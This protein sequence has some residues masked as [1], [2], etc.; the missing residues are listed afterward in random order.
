VR[1]LTS[2]SLRTKITASFILVV[3]AGT[4][5][6]VLVGSRIVTRA[7]L[8]QA[9]QRTAQ[10]LETAR[11]LCTLRQDAVHEAVRRAGVRWRTEGS[12]GESPELDLLA[13]HP[14]GAPAPGDVVARALRGEAS[15]GVELV[16]DRL[17]LGA[18]V[19]VLEKGAVVGAVHGAVHVGAGSPALREIEALVLGGDG[20]GAATG[21]VTITPM[22]RPAAPPREAITAAAPLAGP[23]GRPAGT[24]LVAIRER[25]YLAARTQMMLTFLVVAAAGVLLVLA[26]TL[27]ITRNMI[28]PLEQ[29]AAATRRIAQGDFERGVTATD[30]EDE[31]GLLARSFNQML[32]AIKAMKEDAEG[33]SRT[34]E[35]RVRERTAE[36]A[37]VQAQMAQAEKMASLGSM[38]AGV[39]HELNN[40]MGAIL[41]LS[42][43]A[44][45]EAPPG[46]PAREDLETISRQALR[47]RTIVRGLL[48]FSRQS[49][50][51]ETA[52]DPAHVAEKTLELLSP[53]LASQR[54]TVEPRLA[55]GVPLVRMD[56]GHLQ[57][58]LTNLV[59][60][61][62][63]AMERGGTL[64][65][66]CEGDG[67]EGVLL[68]V[69]DTGGGIPDAVLPS[70]FDPFFTTKRVGK[71]TGLGLSIVHGLVHEVGGRIEVATSPA[72]TTFTVHLPA[73]RPEP[74]PVTG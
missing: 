8:E 21:A 69:A 53:Q 4:A 26:F 25:P 62:A 3:L 66:T 58:V 17:A 65:V 42:L 72:G 64:T 38:A 22:G 15:A 36:L 10:G 41:S 54:I 70:I 24:L 13:F 43:L 48:D 52:M 49:G 59:V 68:R 20:V 44:L 27:V 11:R 46:S 18:A 56:P 31:I 61:A 37:S 5:S 40:P 23:D 60:N 39:A 34:L 57:Q 47:C 45:E 16:G 55:P 32:A 67:Q 33:W 35:A 14:R 29:M 51:P 63:D 30:S 28:H 50:V 73:A 74:V 19:P 71:G 6:S 2:P 7:V 9:R 12:L 1:W